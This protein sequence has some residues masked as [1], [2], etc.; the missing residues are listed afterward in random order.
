MEASPELWK[1]VGKY[2]EDEISIILD[3]GIA[4]YENA[5]NIVI[6]ELND[7][8]SE[9]MEKMRNDVKAVYEKSIALLD[10]EI[11]SIRKEKEDETAIRRYEEKKK[12]EEIENALTIQKGMFDMIEKKN[13]AEREM[14][15]EKVAF[16]ENE[17]G[18]LR[19]CER[20]THA[21]MEARIN[22]KVNEKIRVELNLMENVLREKERQNEQMR[23][24]FEASMEK[25]NK[26]TEKKDVVN[27]GKHGENQFM[28]LAQQAFRDFVGFEIEDVHKMS[29]AG[30]FHIQFKDFNVL[31]DSKLYS[32]KVNST[33][34]EKIKRDLMKQEHIRFAW[35]V[36]LDTMIDRYDK[37][38]FMFEWLS[39][40]QCVCY[41]NCLMKN[42][43]PAEILRA[44]Y[45]CCKTLYDIMQSEEQEINELTELRKKQL[46]IKE[47]GQK[48]VKNKR[49]RETIMTQLMQNMEK[50]DEYIKELLNNETNMMVDEYMSVLLKWWKMRL[51]KCEEGVLTSTVLWN[52][53]KKD[54]A[55]LAKKIDIGIF[56]KMVVDMHGGAEGA[57][58]ASYTRIVQKGNSFELVGMRV[59]NV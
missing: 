47:I 42:E 31:V 27:I 7:V 13:S 32:H 35:L 11:C 20:S 34:R 56:K 18:K 46:L 53:F 52:Q 37:A 33:S 41:V 4:C 59:K 58:Y 57:T 8:N 10:E 9:F 21:G 15:R 40:Q 17:M 22:E 45:F 30:D 24:L 5:R 44:L 6:H 14:L 25:I 51:E 29:S 23:V 26:I 48:M 54:N 36:S 2:R 55:E 28:Q 12:K 16:L 3:L 39:S 19:E 43:E 49:E 50:G 38:P 1:K